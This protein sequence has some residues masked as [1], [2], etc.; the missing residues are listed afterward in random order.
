MA[1]A[2]YNPNSAVDFW[3]RMAQMKGGNEPPEF[4]STH[5]SDQTRINNIKKWLP[6]AMK[7]YNK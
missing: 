4:L 1:M 7:Y 5:P 3:E 6:E 2:G